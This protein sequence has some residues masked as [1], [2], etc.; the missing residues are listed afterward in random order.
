MTEPEAR[1]FLANNGPWSVS[2]REEDNTFT[3]E[4]T[5]GDVITLDL[6]TEPGYPEC[7]WDVVYDFIKGV[8][9]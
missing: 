9:L 3:F 4:N 7:S 1:E 2:F 5:N 6:W 8:R